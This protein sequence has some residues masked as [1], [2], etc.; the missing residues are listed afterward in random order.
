[1]GSAYHKGLD[2]LKKSLTVDLAVAAVRAYYNRI[3]TQTPEQVMALEYECETVACLVNGYEWRW[4]NYPLHIVASEAS[5]RLPLINPGTGAQAR[6]FELAGKVD[7][8]VGL[9]DLRL[10]V[11]EH[12]LLGEKI[13]PD[14]D[15]WLRLQLDHQV[16]LYVDAARRMGHDVKTCLYD[17]ASKPGIKP[18]AV[19]LVDAEGYKIVLDAA[20]KRVMT[21]D[22]KK[23]RETADTKSGWVLQTRPMTVSE[24][25]G[26]LTEDITNYPEVYY[27]RQEIPRLDQD[28]EEYQEELWDIQNVL[29]EAQRNQRW[30]RTVHRDTCSFCPY[31]GL[32]SS[33]CNPSPG[34]VPE[35]F[36]FV[37]NV[38]PEL[39]EED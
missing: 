18:T 20:G 10:A 22:G 6:L 7:G 25:A 11:L 8:I 16:T 9:E 19:P 35:G 26:K 4:R 15:F 3:L 38:H 24:W 31:F 23:P 28:I 36:E 34:E 37:K 2:T 12:K 5:F 27:A 21:K 39:N 1:M 13:T 14:S 17:V 33:T 30:Y 32:C 29:R